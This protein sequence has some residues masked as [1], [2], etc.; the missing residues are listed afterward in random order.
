MAV[1]LLM[2]SVAMGF[3]A[4][5]VPEMNVFIIGFGLRGLVG[6]WVLVLTIPLMA[7]V[8]QVL[9]EKAARESGEILRALAGS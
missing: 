1:V 9:F 5:A 6:L 4:R 3:L 7:R 2:V 8:F